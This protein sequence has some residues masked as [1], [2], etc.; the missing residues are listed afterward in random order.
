MVMGLSIVLATI[1]IVILSRKN[2]F[3]KW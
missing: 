3:W 1:A 2:M